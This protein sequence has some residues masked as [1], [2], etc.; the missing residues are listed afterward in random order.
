MDA[1]LSS[2]LR[3]KKENLLLE[4]ESGI[5]MK[6][7][8]NLI[9]AGLPKEIVEKLD[10]EQISSTD[11]LFNELRKHDHKNI[12]TWRIQNVIDKTTSLQVNDRRKYED[13]QKK[14]TETGKKPC[15]IC[16]FLNLLWIMTDLSEVKS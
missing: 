14:V 12:H 13:N 15:S 7:R 4:I 5:I 10:R 2:R 6:S 9:V 11:L 1:R 8:I 16:K 3:I